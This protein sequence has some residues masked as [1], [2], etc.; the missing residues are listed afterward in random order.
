V[1]E[2]LYRGGQP[3]KGGIE[4]LSELGIKTIIN[5]RG[6]DEQTR[7][8]EA[9]AK[10]ANLSYFNIP[11]PGLSRPAHEQVSRVMTIIQAEENWPVFIHCKRGSDRTGTI[12]AIY[13]ISQDKWTASEAMSEAKSF[14]LSWVEFGMKD[15]ISDYYRD[16][17]AGKQKPSEKM[18]QQTTKGS[19]Q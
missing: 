5:L 1:N 2:R 9:E 19:I 18:G 14:G 13:R 12:V 6:E 3:K 4:Q 11:M 8:E 17:N 16:R 10:A 15:Y 7:A